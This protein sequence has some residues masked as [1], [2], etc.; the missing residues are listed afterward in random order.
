MGRSNDCETSSS[1]SLAERLRRESPAEEYET[2]SGSSEVARTGFRRC[3]RQLHALS[4]CRVSCC[5]PRFPVRAAGRPCDGGCRRRE[6]CG[7]GYDERSIHFDCICPVNNSPPVRRS[8][9]FSV[10]VVTSMYMMGMTKPLSRGGADQTAQY[11]WAIGLC[12]SLPGDVAVHRE[13]D[14]GEGPW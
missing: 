6:R 7:D 11:H 12:I 13:G 1:P 3:G 10:R 14:E 5:V 4:A 2:D 8:F 9:R